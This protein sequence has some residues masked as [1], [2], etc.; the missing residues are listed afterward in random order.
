MGLANRR[1]NSERILARRR[2]HWKA[3][4]FPWVKA[5]GSLEPAPVGHFLKTTARPCSCY[6][7]KRPRYKRAPKQAAL[8][9]L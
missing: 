6:V 2:K 4:A 3:I 8:E 9:G 7:C 1:H 5:D